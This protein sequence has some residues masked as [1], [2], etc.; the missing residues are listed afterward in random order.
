MSYHIYTTRGLVLSSRPQGEA[1]RVYSILTRD[2]GLIWASARAVR[3][4]ESKLR[5]ALEPFSLSQISLVKGRERWRAT[6]AEHIRTVTR[7]I[8]IAQ[9]LALLERLVQGE[10]CHT[11]LFDTVELALPAPELDD[12]F[13][14]KLVSN[15][16]YHLGYLRKEDLT[17]AKRDLTQAINEG[18][19]SSGLV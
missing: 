14:I 16:L 8:F 10:A 12:D 1:D 7:S 15:I 19:R 3:K 17:L 9:P 5:G 2:L 4:E 6:S 11:E 13:E 18:I